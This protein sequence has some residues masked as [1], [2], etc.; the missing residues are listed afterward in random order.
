MLA[1]ILPGFRDFRTPLVTGYLWLVVL[2][3][4]I[5]MPL[6]DKTVTDGATGVINAFGSFLTPT[7]YVAVL[8]FLAYVIGMLLMMDVKAGTE[9]SIFGRV[10]LPRVSKRS[11]E[12]INRVIEGSLHRAKLA[13]VNGVAVAREFDLIYLIGDAEDYS[14][15]RDENGGD[16]VQINADIRN[17]ALNQVSTLMPTDIAEALPSLAI[18][19][20]EKNADLYGTYDRDKSESEFR[21]SIALPII[22][23]SVYTISDN[24]GPQNYT[25]IWGVVG[26]VA[27]AAL[28]YKGV[29]KRYSAVNVLITALDLSMIESPM[30]E[31]LRMV[32]EDELKRDES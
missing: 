12:T 15:L 16:E 11:S 20:Q 7:V 25:W 23:L 27:A 5:R 9:L 28:T 14:Q 6:P 29:I 19:L 13:R 10:I 17:H 22:A 26:L 2:W 18:K 30:I 32:F 8:S 1:Q 21:L 24:I 3:V 4:C 31:R